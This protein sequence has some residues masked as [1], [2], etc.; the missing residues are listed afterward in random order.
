MVQVAGAGRGGELRRRGRKWRGKHDEGGR[1][2]WQVEGLSYKYHALAIECAWALAFK[3][4]QLPQRVPI[5]IITVSPTYYRA[6]FFKPFMLLV[7]YN[8]THTITVV[9]LASTN[10]HILVMPMALYLQLIFINMPWHA[11]VL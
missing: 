3:S 4:M 10:K 6:P 11:V 1:R 7:V 9:T 2:W 8:G 5:S